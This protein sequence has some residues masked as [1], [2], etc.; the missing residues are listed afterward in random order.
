MVQRIADFC[1]F[2]EICGQK[3]K[4]RI[5]PA[6]FSNISSHLYDWPVFNTK[7]KLNICQNMSTNYH[8]SLHNEEHIHYLLFAC[9]S[10]SRCITESSPCRNPKGH[11]E[12]DS[13]EQALQTSELG[14]SQEE[15]DEDDTRSA[16]CLSIIQYEE[17]PAPQGQV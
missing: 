10:S 9:L 2:D 13:Q 16:V 15:E 8:I 12:E 5:T 17:G 11:P 6:L 14:Y 4:C 3:P 1:L 7:P